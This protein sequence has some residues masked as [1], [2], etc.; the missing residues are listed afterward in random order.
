MN[1]HF[2]ISFLV[3]FFSFIFFFLFSKI[4]F[5]RLIDLNENGYGSKKKTL[6]G[7]GIIFLLVLAPFLLYYFF[8]QNFYNLLPNRFYIFIIGISLISLLSFYDDLKPIHPVYRL[9]FQFIIVYFSLTLLKIDFLNIPLKILIFLTLLWWIYL[10]NITNFI[11]GADGFLVINALFFFLGIL[12]FNFF[13]PG[14]LFSY[15]L[16]VILVPIL[17]SFFYFNKPVAKLYMGDTGSIFLGYIIGFCFLEIFF[18]G[19]WFFVISLYLYPVIDCSITLIKKVLKGYA[20][21]ARLFDYYFL[22]PIKKKQ[23]NNKKVL[24]ISVIYNIFNL[25]N[26]YYMLYLNNLY[27]FV[28]SV[29]LVFIKIFFYKKIIN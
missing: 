12:I 29:I 24:V 19:S 15:Y 17:I 7:A 20:P 22:I 18:I 2:L 27:L 26:I 10:I 11:D 5:K 6:T 1:T 4:K 13:Y 28:I 8:N 25:L 14:R 3:L 16:A 9:I 21:W 23:K